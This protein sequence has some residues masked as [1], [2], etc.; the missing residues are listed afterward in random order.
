MKKKLTFPS[1]PCRTRDHKE[2]QQ[3]LQ[4]WRLHTYKYRTEEEKNDN[5]CVNISDLY[6]KTHSAQIKLYKIDE[7][8]KVPLLNGL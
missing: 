1:T 7:Q 6:T 4:T 3:A 8:F 5:L 2:Y